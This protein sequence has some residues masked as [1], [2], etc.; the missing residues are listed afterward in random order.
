MKCKN[1]IL[2]ALAALSI[3]VF[4]PTCEIGLGESVDTEPPTGSISSPGVNAV[5]RDAFLLQGQW[6]DEAG[7][8]QVAVELKYNSEGNNKGKK[9]SYDAT[10]NKDNTW[11]CKIDPESKT[12]P[13]VDG[14]YLATI[15]IYDNGGHQTKLERS[16]ILDNTPPVIVLQRP[17]S[18]LSSSA[19]DTDTYGQKFTIQGQ[20]ADDNNLNKIE[21]EIYSDEECT[22]DFLLKT[23]TLNNV[24]LAINNDVASYVSGDTEKE[25]DYSKIYFAD[26]AYQDLNDMNASEA[27]KTRYCKIIAYDGAQRYPAKGEE[28]DDDSTGNKQTN[29]YLYDD[30]S[31]SILSTYK[32]NELYAMFNGTYASSD[33]SRSVATTTS[34]ILE[35]LEDKAQTVAKFNLNPKNNPTFSVSGKDQLTDGWT[36][37][38]AYNI[39]SGS[40]VVVEVS[41]GLDGISLNKDSLKVYFVEYNATTKK[42]E[43]V[44]FYPVTERQ[45]Y[46]SG[47]KFITTINSSYLGDDNTSKTKIGSNYIFGVEGWDKSNG[48]EAVGNTIIASGKGYGFHLASSGVAP[49]LNPKFEISENGT[50]WTEVTDTILYLKAGT[51][52]KVSGTVSVEEGTPDFSL[53]FGDTDSGAS[54]TAI[55]N[56][57]NNFSFTKKFEPNAF[58]TKTSQRQIT[59][60][61]WQDKLT[62]SK[63]YTVYYDLEAPTI[64]ISE[65]KP[66]ACKYTGEAGTIDGKQYLNGDNVSIKLTISDN[67]S[68]YT[69]SDDATDE[70][71][72]KNP[73]IEIEDSTGKIISNTNV[74]T[75][76]NF[77]WDNIPTTQLA[78]GPITIRVTAYDRAG[79]KKE[80]TNNNFEVD[81]DTDKPVILP[82][83]ASQLTFTADSEDLPASKNKFASGSQ[84]ILKLIDDDGLASITPWLGTNAT[85]LVEKSAFSLPVSSTSET[86]TYNLPTDVGFHT[87]R[88]KLTDSNGKS[89]Y[90]PSETG[91]FFVKITAGAPTIQEV[92][93]VVKDGTGAELDAIYTKGDTSDTARYF[94]NKVN[95]DSEYTKFNIY[96]STDNTNFTAIASDIEEDGTSTIENEHGSLAKVS[97]TWV[98]TD[99]LHRPAATTTYYYYVAGVDGT[100]EEKSNKKNVTCKVDKEVPVV[101]LSALPGASDTKATSYIFSATSK[102][103]GGSGIEKIVLTITDKTDESKTMTLTEEGQGAAIASLS[104]TVTYANEEVFTGSDGKALEGYKK[105]TLK[106]IDTAGNESAK[107]TF[108]G[109]TELTS[110]EFLYDK[111]KPTLSVTSDLREY[112][113]N[114]GYTISGS[115]SDSYSIKSLKITETFTPKDTTASKVEKT[116]DIIADVG[117]STVPAQTFADFQLPLD[118]TSGTNLDDGTYSYSITLT[119]KK[120][121]EDTITFASIVDKTAPTVT[122][123]TP[124]TDDSYKAEN[125]ISGKT[126]QFEGDLE[127]DNSLS[128]VYYAIVANGAAAPSVPTADVTTAEAWE[129][130]GFTK[131]TNF[132]TTN[133]KTKKNFRVKGSDPDSAYP[134]SL[135]EGSQYKIIVY[136]VDKAGN[137]GHTKGASKAERSFD[138]DMAKPDIKLTP[139]ANTILNINTTE[140]QDGKKGEFYIQGTSTDSLGLEKVE[141]TYISDAQKEADED[142]QTIT[143]SATNGALSSD[144]SWKQKFVYGSEATASNGSIKLTDGIYTFNIK[145]TDLIGK[146]KELDEIV[147]TVDTK[148]PDIKTSSLKLDGSTYSSTKYY[149]SKALELI[150]NVE[151]GSAGSGISKVQVATKN[152]SG[153]KVYKSCSL[154][155][156]STVEWTATVQFYNEGDN[157]LYI[158]AKDKA[159]NEIETGSPITVK[160]DTTAPELELDKYQIGNGS[161]LDAASTI[162][163][164]GTSTL[165]LYGTYSD[166]QSGVRELS[167]SGTKNNDQPADGNV[168]YSIKTTADSAASDYDT[169]GN[170]TNKLKIQSWKAVFTNGTDGIIETG[171]WK[172]KGR[173]NAGSS[174][175][176][177]EKNLFTLNKDVTKPVLKNISLATDNDDYSVYKK[178]EEGIVYYYANNQTGKF[179]I[180]GLAEDN[181]GT[182][183]PASGVDKV[184]ITI[185]NTA[186]PTKKIEKEE[187]SVNFYDILLA[188]TDAEGNVT[189]YWTEGATATVTVFD[190]AG[191]ECQ[192]PTV[193]NIKFDTEGPAGVHSID[194]SG[195]DL[196]FRLGENDND[197]IDRS[198]SDWNGGSAST[199]KIDQDVGG[200]YSTTTYGNAQTVTV[201]G[202]FNDTGSGVEKI[203]YYIAS[204]KA[205]AN[206]VTVE[207]FRTKTS[208]Y[209]TPIVE[210]SKETVEQQAKRRVFYTDTLNNGSLYNPDST[211]TEKYNTK[212]T[213]INVKDASTKRYYTSITSTFKATIPGFTPNESNY[214]VLIAVDNVGNA[215]VDGMKLV[216]QEEGEPSASL[217]TYSNYL[218]NVDT[219]VPDVPSLSGYKLNKYIKPS[220]DNQKITITGTATDNLSGVASLVVKINNGNKEIKKDITTFGTI[221]TISSGK[222]IKTSDDKYNIVQTNAQNEE[223]VIEEDIGEEYKDVTELSSKNTWWKAE[224]KNTAFAGVGVSSGSNIVVEL[225]AKDNAGLSKTYT[226]GTVVVDTEGPTVK[227][228][229]VPNAGTAKIGSED[230]PLVNGASLTIEGSA[231]DSASGLKANTALNLYYTT[232][233]SPSAPTNDTISETASDVGT[234]WIKY[235]PAEGLGG[236]QGNTWEF[237]IDTTQLKDNTVTYFSVSSEDDVGNIGYSTPYKVKI[238]Q[239]SDRPIITLSNLELATT[240]GATTYLKSTKTLYLTVT[241]DDGVSKIEYKKTGDSDFV[242]YSNGVTNLAEGPNTVQFKITDGAGGV[243]TS[244]AADTTVAGNTISHQPKITDG[245]TTIS[246]AL[247]FNVVTE[248]PHIEKVQYSYYDSESTATTEEE[249]W[250]AYADTLRTLGGKYTKLKLKISASSAQSIASITGTYHGSSDVA[251]TFNCKD[252]N[253]NDIN[254]HD[255]ESGAIALTSA[256]NFEGRQTIDIVVSDI[257][258]PTPMTTEKSYSI[259]IDNKAPEL[260]ISK[261]DAGKQLSRDQTVRGEIKNESDPKL[262]YAV[263]RYAATAADVQPDSN[264]DKRMGGENNTVVLAT[265]WTEIEHY[266]D[267]GTWYVYF[268]GT[269][270]TSEEDHTEKFATYLT[271]EYLNL[272]TKQNILDN[273]YDE[274]PAV[275]FWIKAE[276]DCGNKT[277]LH[278]QYDIDPYGER[279]EVTITYPVDVLKK[280]STTEYEAPTLGGTI[281]MTGTATDNNEAKYVWVQI[282]KDSTV[283]FS[284]DELKFLKDNGYPIGQISTNKPLASVPASLDD[285]ADAAADYGIMVPV[286]GS[287][288]ALN[289]NANGEFDPE[290]DKARLTIRVYATD[291][292]VDANSKKTIHKSK[293]KTQVIYIDADAPYSENLK[294]VQYTTGDTIGAQKTYSDGVSVKGIWYLTGNYIDASSGIKEIKYK[295][296]NQTEKTVIASGGDSYTSSSD[297]NLWFKPIKEDG[298]D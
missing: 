87:L 295:A 204:S 203:Y 63:T 265:K 7:I 69:A 294:L 261:P 285:G 56:S 276:D 98:Y 100:D 246:K 26:E 128:G 202:T 139:L 194:T 281:R 22:E 47:Y 201:R 290:S 90:V 13:L 215:K 286:S 213:D 48:D 36:T 43:S 19:S 148:M 242:L 52:V 121:N 296:E 1:F 145:A 3:F 108:D 292:D 74:T 253:H 33:S 60:K 192:Q 177:T 142:A 237:K 109:N 238:N 162:Y 158:T 258:T 71:K 244:G 70:E 185:V 45:A 86:Y 125:A 83:S 64:S 227:I 245:T 75:L 272:T 205:D 274:I 73:K 260:S 178:T 23:I 138:V 42:V 37:N 30:I 58:G 262:Y 124:E 161:V 155:D 228:N 223:T 271:E 72:S 235:N 122:I 266:D 123:T 84:L 239:D 154:T 183:G 170:I 113:P 209:F 40:Q 137:V 88:F 106:A 131:V 82:N 105:I 24:P 171:D 208:N 236:T 96:R 5:I 200:K 251:V 257:V 175:V 85:N 143:F 169:F 41:P 212:I 291:E 267:A 32:V 39:S 206:G 234:K 250:S 4:F 11:T 288:W 133:W 78:D 210:T 35:Q 167:F 150:V 278:R 135:E 134:D 173:N 18:I 289:L 217:K 10:I 226:V 21:V 198:N 20:A 282:D 211:G 25:S 172:V 6:H 293:V 9:Y 222:V 77:V 241:D 79:N 233:D 277:I 68:V 176:P 57:E 225:E 27:S 255:W 53:L 51:Y 80:I 230:V 221:K 130:K 279:P 66:I 232:K 189:A 264:T 284:K 49:T 243:F 268:D 67:D 81:Q 298:T 59:V 180:S 16:Y 91:C 287:S 146:T 240:S 126:F 110:T 147:L 93:S 15:V 184:K 104:K 2:G 224:I 118:Y 191:N 12:Q 152:A 119:D 280:D 157:E 111:A 190:K 181:R 144:N 55:E 61:A 174:G 92:K 263:S 38:D 14:T 8:K 283:G 270:S 28:K 101:V 120:G 166:A 297:S 112:M 214:L 34:S 249:K 44:K 163:I 127:E 193:L 62:T 159:G 129:N 31:G 94:E 196:F 207:N 231:T 275:Y 156:N 46:G 141:I 65:V 248:T 29:Y 140:D 89:T 218:I 99:T 103:T 168:L 149:E 199:V 50:A 259:S 216:T 116:A 95:F 187:S 97:G 273:K 160:V 247:S 188:D 197:D 117:S 164:N 114:E 186:V 219:T 256:A 153:N 102:D 151:D 220:D 107:F 252:N 115:V 17:S 132:G 182:E 254:L 54:L 76:I 179:K 136:A 195:K 165:T 269:D 229:K